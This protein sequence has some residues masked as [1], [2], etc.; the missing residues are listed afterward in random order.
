MENTLDIPTIKAH[1][2][3]CS[4]PFLVMDLPASE[5]PW[6]VRVS[7]FPIL[8]CVIC[9][10]YLFGLDCWA[11]VVPYYIFVV[12]YWSRERAQLEISTRN[13]HYLQSD[14]FSGGS[15]SQECLFQLTHRISYAIFYIR[16]E[17]GRSDASQISFPSCINVLRKYIRGNKI[18]CIWSGAAGT[19]QL[20]A[21]SLKAM[22]AISFKNLS[23][24]KVFFHAHPSLT[25]GSNV[26]FGC[27]FTSD[28]GLPL[29][30]TTAPS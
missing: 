3:S 20:S 6:Q 24:S 8:Y 17:V 13:S 14:F 25:A 15:E 28:T 23:L 29:E 30:W 9:L 2:R 27:T 4:W 22:A 18:A 21:L 16:T 26:S 12:C 19:A 7:L 11:I 1:S 10:R 5:G